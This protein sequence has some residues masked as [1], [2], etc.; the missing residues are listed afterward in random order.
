MPILLIA[1]VVFIVLLIAG[2]YLEELSWKQVGVWVVIA[3]VAYFVLVGVVDPSG[4]LFSAALA[5]IDL[6]LAVVVF[7]SYVGRL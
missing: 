4:N 2:I 3:I 1:I 6:V 7:R 5:V